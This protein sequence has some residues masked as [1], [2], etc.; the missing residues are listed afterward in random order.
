[1]RSSTPNAG[2]L[3]HL[4]EDEYSYSVEPGAGAPSVTGMDKNL[5]Q[6]G[7]ATSR[8][9]RVSLAAGVALS[10]SALTVPTGAAEAAE[11]VSRV[12]L[13]DP[14]GDVWAISEGE[15]EEWVLAGDEPGLDVERAVVHHRRHKLAVT[16]TFTNLRRVEAQ[17]YSATFTTSKHYGAVFVSAEPGR[18]KGRSELV[19]E[20]FG[21]VRCRGL[22]HTIDY[23][24]E[25]VVLSV[26]RKCIGKPRW[27][28]VAMA[29]YG[30]RGETEADFHQLTDNPHSTGHE[31]D[32]QTRRLYRQVL[33]NQMVSIDPSGDVVKHDDVGDD[34]VTIV[35]P[36][37]HNGDI[38]RLRARHRHHRVTARLTFAALEAGSR[39]PW[40][41]HRFLFV[42]DSGGHELRGTVGVDGGG[43]QGT[44]ELDGR[45]VTC[46]GL[47]HAI[48]YRA[49]TVRVSV[50]RSCLGRP[51]WV[52]VGGST[53]S[54]SEAQ[55]TY[56]SDD[57]LSTGENATLDPDAP[58]PLLVGRRL[59]RG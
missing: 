22:K 20:Q 55:E 8:P 33:P 24:T 10:L 13:T 14:T 45:R 5:H 54:W 16:M 1:M 15:D 18:W 4:V 44:W 53:A 47:R 41:Y 48:D 12:V 6:G 34:S 29:D 57:G 28:R 50:P 59:S 7:R 43:G 32:P 23:A 40:T 30:F 56:R 26:P 17:F 3:H 51:T 25:K 37:W 35:D 2:E 38:T 49:D 39:K 21:Q 52:R 58:G 42:T 31:E 36:T 9:W 27:V 46:R 19:D 11:V